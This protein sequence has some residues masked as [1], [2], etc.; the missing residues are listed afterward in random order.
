MTDEELRLECIK[1]AADVA[2]RGFARQ[3]VVQHAAEM[4]E[5]VRGPSLLPAR[6]AEKEGGDWIDWR[7]GP[8]EADCLEWQR[9][10]YAV[11][12]AGQ[13]VHSLEFDDGARWDCVSGWTSFGRAAIPNALH[14]HPLFDII[15]GKA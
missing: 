12:I 13:R 3:D 2:A 14:P 5:F 15:R 7:Y 11:T 1:L 8:I 6:F 9:D 4:V 10:P